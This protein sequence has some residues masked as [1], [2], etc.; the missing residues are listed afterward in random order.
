M[1]KKRNKTAPIHDGIN[2]PANSPLIPSK[3]YVKYIS[4]RNMSTNQIVTIG[5]VNNGA[6]RCSGIISRRP[7]LLRYFSI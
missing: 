3:E 2:K 7:S 6:R 5:R 4:I 1:S